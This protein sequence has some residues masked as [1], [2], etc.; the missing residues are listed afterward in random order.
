VPA[1]ITPGDTVSG[2]TIGLPGDIDEFT[3]S[4]TAGEQFNVFL[5]ATNP[6]PPQGVVLSV[7]TPGDVLLAGTQSLTAG[8]DLLSLSTGRFALPVGGTYRVRVDGSVGPYRLFV[9][10]VNPRPESVADTL[11][12]GDS[13]IDEAIDVP[14][15]VDEFAVVVAD[16]SLANLVFEL[17][18]DATHGSINASLL[19]RGSGEQIT[20]TGSSTP[21]GASQTGRFDIGPGSYVL[22]IENPPSP[23][24]ARG[25]YRVML[26]RFRAGPERVSDSIVVGDTI[27]GEGLDPPG[28]VDRFYLYG[29][30]GEHINLAIQG[31]AG[32]TS[33]GGFEAFLMQPN[34]WP[35][36]LV[37]SPTSGSSLDEHQTLR[38]DLP[39]TGRYLLDISGASTPDQLTEHGSYR[40]AVTHVP[41]TPE[42]TSA[43]LAPGDSVTTESI[44][45]LGD[46]DQFTVAATPGENL[47]LLFEST[48]T[49]IYP[50]ISAF[51][52]A[53]GDNL[54]GTVGQFRRFAGPFRVPSGGQVAIA[55]Y[56]APSVYFRMC[57]APTCDGIFR[58]VGGYKFH[59]IPVHL[60]PES[61]PATYTVGDTVRGEAIDPEGDIDEFTA[62]G[63]PGETLAPFYRL[64]ANP[65]PT[66]KGI[67][68][69]VIDPA[70]GDTLVG[71]G[72][73]IVGV[74]QEFISSGSFTVPASGHFLIRVRGSGTFGDDIAT[75]P[76]EMFIRR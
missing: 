30:R 43:A 13:V 25:S 45:A 18:P 75:A 57:Y 59:V 1:V 20:S 6:S 76:Y 14:G 9:Y 28:D 72:L 67:T 49:G 44:D 48:G 21:G 64:T 8:A 66:G 47:G 12:F 29:T 46:W 58:F 33:N 50:L 2:E 42:N 26:Y 15:D 3:F 27:D 65:V 60:A 31:M 24:P 39:V 54:G 41:T 10:H 70:T 17:G 55:V 22:R 40:L 38:L 74:T 62:N 23:S 5:Q 4:G 52:P 35:F 63:T 61:G 19:R 56:E 7:I 32:L 71:K 69:E 11:A 37:A 16:S 53:T 34:G 36:A 73:Q 51:D 68:L